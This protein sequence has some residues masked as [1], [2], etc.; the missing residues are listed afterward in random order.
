MTLTTHAAVGATVAALFPSYPAVGL[1]AAFASHFAL[2]AI[3][4]WDY[5]LRSYRRD[6]ENP[7]NN[8]LALNGEFVVD[9]SKIAFDFVLG[10]ALSVSLFPHIPIL[11]VIGGFA[12]MLPDALQFAYFKIRRQPLTWLQKFHYSVHSRHRLSHRPVFGAFLQL[13]IIGGVAL[14]APVLAVAYL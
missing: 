11:A 14:L 8:D 5:Q 9:I 12:G 1:I 13:L 7:L 4:H 6:P 3:P 10:L 2:D